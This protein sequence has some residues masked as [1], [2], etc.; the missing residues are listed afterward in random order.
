M[1]AALGCPW[2]ERRCTIGNTCL[3]GADALITEGDESPDN[4]LI[5]V[6]R[7]AIRALE[8]EAMAYG[9]G[10]SSSDASA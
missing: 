2:H 7:Q 4:S 5:A 10:Q 9:Y 8:I 3:V 1:R 6:A